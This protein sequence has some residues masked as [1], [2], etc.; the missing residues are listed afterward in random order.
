MGKVVKSFLGAV[1]LGSGAKAPKQYYVM[2]SAPTPKPEAAEDLSKEQ[3]QNKKAR[4]ALLETAGGAAGQEV[5]E[6]GV[7]KRKTLLG[8]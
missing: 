5:D 7:K 8:N 2:P 6:S 4:A 1:G 3:R